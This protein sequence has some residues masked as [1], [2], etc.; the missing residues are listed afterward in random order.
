[1]ARL[2]AAL[3]REYEDNDEVHIEVHNPRNTEAVTLNFRGEK[4]AKVR[5]QCFLIC[6]TVFSSGVKTTCYLAS[7]CFQFMS[8]YLFSRVSKYINILCLVL[9]GV[10]FRGFYFEVVFLMFWVFL[11]FFTLRNFS[12]VMSQKVCR[13][14]WP[15]FVFRVNFTLWFFWGNHISSPWLLEAVNASDCLVALYVFFL[16]RWWDL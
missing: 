14:V 3:I 2:K 15:S 10:W 16:S 4:L 8:N 7:L 9:F 12:C 1:M 6:R 5:N 11:W 13:L